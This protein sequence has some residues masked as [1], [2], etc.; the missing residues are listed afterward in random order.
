MTIVIGLLYFVNFL[1]K[2]LLHMHYAYILH[3]S[4]VFSHFL[5]S[6]SGSEYSLT[7]IHLFSYLIITSL[8]FWLYSPCFNFLSSSFLILKPWSVCYFIF[9]Y[10]FPPTH[11]LNPF[12]KPSFSFTYLSYKCVLC[13]EFSSL[14]S[15]YMIFLFLY[16][17]ADSYVTV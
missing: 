17:S 2:S 1:I 14:K 6:K 3:V 11:T 7:F 8:A 5:I 12:F 10:H 4:I 16:F 9:T 13:D 15:S